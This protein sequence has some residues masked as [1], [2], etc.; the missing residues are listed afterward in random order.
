MT[1]TRVR[2]GMRYSMR[3]G[4]GTHKLAIRTNAPL[5]R[6]TKDLKGSLLPTPFPVSE[7]K[8]LWRKPDIHSLIVLYE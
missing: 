2:D 4:F 3:D 8:P 5:V 7:A 1:S 6:S